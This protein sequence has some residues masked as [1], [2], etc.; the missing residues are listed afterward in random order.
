MISLIAGIAA[1]VMEYWILILLMQY[2]CAAHMELNGKNAGIGTGISVLSTVIVTFCPFPG[3]TFAGMAAEIFFGM[4]GGILLSVLLF[5]QRRLPDMLRFL[6]AFSI[7]F[8][9]AV[10]PEALIEEFLPEAMLQPMLPDTVLTPLYVLVDGMLLILLLILRRVQVKYRVKMYFTAKE[11][12]CS[13]A[14][15]F[16]AFIDGAFIVM[17][18]RVNY[19]PVFYYT[20]TV[21]FVGGYALGV[22][23]FLY[24]LIESRARICRQAAARCETEYL[25]LQLDSLREEKEDEAEVKKM[26]H[27][28][29]KH[30]AVISSLCAEGNYEEVRRYAEQ[31]SHGAMRADGRILTGNQV[32]DLVVASKRKTCEEYGIRFTY[33]GTMQNLNAM[34]AP[35]ICGLLANAYDNAIEACLTQPEGYI[36]TEVKTTRNYTVIEIVNSVEKKVA[37]RGNSVPT[38]KKDRKAHGYG[39]EIMKQIAQRYS[40]SCTVSC[41][42]K[43]FCVKLVLLTPHPAN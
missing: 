37:V 29:N 41:D 30:L 42:E 35:D 12:L 13:I 33:A 10:V 21:I 36:R 31:L 25:R 23:Y 9:L 17:L 7:Y 28:L 32:A 18:N 1:N 3:D 22:G 40:G 6:P 5:S 11:I 8:F 43:E 24:S 19:T 16:F 2:V 15:L 39:I 4:V 34:A 14:L 20:L 26:R 27:D 38:T